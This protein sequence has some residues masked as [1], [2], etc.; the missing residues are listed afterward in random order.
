MLMRKLGRTELNVSAICLGGNVF[1]WTC[2]EPTS[3]A[4]LDAFVAGGGNFIDTA[5][6]YSAWVPGNQGGESETILGRWLATR[7]NRDQVIIATKVG[8]QMGNDPKKKGLSRQYIMQAVDASLQRL[9][10]DYIDLYQAHWDD[11]DTPLE[12][13]LE[14]FND[15][16]KQ[17]KVRYIGASNYN[18]ARLT[19]ALKVSLKKGIARYESL[20]PNYNLVHRQEYEEALAP[21]CKEQEIGVISYYSLASGFLSGKYRQGQ[22]LP[23]TPRAQGIKQQFM[24]DRGW[25]VIDELD[26]IARAHHVGMSQVALAW[27]IASGNVTAP[28]ASAT[29]IEQTRELL[30][31]TELRLTQDEGEALD[32][33]SVWRTE[34]AKQAK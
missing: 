4:V 30:A 34:A 22:A 32:R 14:A 1:G 17:G 21:L 33:A 20:Q 19:E 28:I 16:I 26:K 29:S 12:E 3:F 7:K 8:S 24:N 25:A 11:P 18:A 23:Q 15:L 5:D 27:L 6:V 2:D 13:T 9:Q 10:T 31:A